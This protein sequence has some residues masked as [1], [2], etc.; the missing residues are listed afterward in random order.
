MIVLSWLI[1]GLVAGCLA[2]FLRAGSGLGIVADIAI[3]VSGAVL[4]GFIV[5]WLVDTP[6]VVKGIN[7]ENLFGA[8]SGGVVT[9][10]L[11]GALP[12]RSEE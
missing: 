11:V 12:E 5:S 3:G 7:L 8:L 9:V 1:I 6:H 4:G 10:I 2:G